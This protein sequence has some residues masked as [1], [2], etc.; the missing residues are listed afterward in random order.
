M[1]A[2]YQQHGFINTYSLKTKQRQQT[3]DQEQQGASKIIVILKRRLQDQQHRHMEPSTRKKRRGNP[4]DHPTC[5]PPPKKHTSVEDNTFKSE[6]EDL[7]TELEYSY[8]CLATINV[9]YTSLRHTYAE[10]KWSIEQQG[11]ATRLCD[12]EK[13][14]LIAFDDLNLQT[15]QLEKSIIKMEQKLIRLKSNAG[16]LRS[17]PLC[18]LC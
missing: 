17:L 3:S 4:P 18:L 14:L 11:H 2:H 13:E 15:N 9:V 1:P 8:D 10:S 12:M 6:F 16:A 5:K 7:I